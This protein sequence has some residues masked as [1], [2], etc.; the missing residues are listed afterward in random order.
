MDNEKPRD[1]KG[2]S[3]DANLPVDNTMRAR[4]RTVMLTPDMTNKVRARLAASE[5]EMDEDQPVGVYVWV[6]DV[7]IYNNKSVRKTGDV[8]LLR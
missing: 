2:S 1:D 4:N 8:T 7:D 6:L 3:R 5:V